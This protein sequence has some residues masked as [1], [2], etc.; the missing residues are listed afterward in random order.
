MNRTIRELLQ[1]MLDNQQLFKTGLCSWIS[2]LEFEG[3]ITSYE[4]WRLIYYINKNRPS[5]WSSIQAF[6]NM[7]SKYYWPKG[8]IKSRIKWIKKHIE[9][10]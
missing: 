6:I 1:I 3:L 5:R 2:L 4:Y 8:N 9:K 10:N 7:G